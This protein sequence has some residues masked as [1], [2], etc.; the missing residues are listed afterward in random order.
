MSV[1][2]LLDDL[3]QMRR[4]VDAE[5]AQAKESGTHD[6]LAQAG[7]LLR[8]KRFGAAVRLLENVR[9]LYPH[10]P[11]VAAR[12]ELASA[13]RAQEGAEHPTGTT[14]DG[15]RSGGVDDGGMAL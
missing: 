1:Q 10:E 2:P 3:V 15:D 13:R 7:A 14:P 4:R 8:S 9:R 5:E 11:R 12:L 6:A